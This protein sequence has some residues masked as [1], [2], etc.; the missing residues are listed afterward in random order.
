MGANVSKENHG[1]IHETIEEVT[2]KAKDAFAWEVTL[3]N[4]KPCQKC[5]AALQIDFTLA[6]EV[7][8]LLVLINLAMKKRELHVLT[9]WL[10]CMRE[11]K[12]YE[13]WK[14]NHYFM[15]AYSN[16]DGFHEKMLR[17]SK[18]YFNEKKRKAN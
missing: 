7:P 9:V 10:R 13:F 4:Q 3:G 18:G 6:E 1:H 15:I 14:P 11:R 5:G 2:Q 8:D 12:W 16:I 17:V